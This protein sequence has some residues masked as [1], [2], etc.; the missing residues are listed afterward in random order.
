M[1]SQS[2]RFQN[3]DQQQLAAYLE[4]P[5]D[6]KTKAYA[7]FAHCFTC[8]KNLKAVRNI[9]RA[10]TQGGFAVLRFDFTGL[11]ESEGDFADTNFSSNVDD[12]LAAAAYLE[13]EY[14]APKLLVGHSL[15]GTAVLMASRR[16]KSAEAVVTIGSP[17][18]PEHVSRLFKNDLGKIQKEGYAEVQL[19][20][21][22][23]TIKKQFLDDLK[24]IS[25]KKL[26]GKLNRALLIMHAP[27]D[28]TVSIDNAATI[29]QEALHPKSFI[30]L[31]TADHLLSDSQDSLYAGNMIVAWV[32]RYVQTHTQTR[33]TT[34]KQVVSRTLDGF[35]TEITTDEHALL[36]DE[37]LEVGGSDLGPSP[38]ELLNASL[39]ACTGMTLRMYADHKKWPLNEVR[40]HLQHKK[41]HA[42][43]CDSCEKNENKIDQIERTIELE[44]DLNEDQ[45]KR[46]MEI[47]DKCPVHRTLS[48]AVEVKSV[49][50]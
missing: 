21:R 32:N 42:Q 47:A 2:I 35:T 8:N 49:L 4:L 50:R 26:L 11:G 46:L 9:S 12:L 37:P 3:Q 24:E 40:V 6:G 17:A 25:D 13:K 41:I 23:F 28:E 16:V 29:Y 36:A 48:S 45:K 19:G 27:G 30:S 18:D 10:L 43:D 15:G 7:I 44:G 14:E 20:G 33:L 39:G 34:D 1:G 22:P 5:P 38:Y 31:D